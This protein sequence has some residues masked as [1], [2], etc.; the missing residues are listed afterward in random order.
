MYRYGMALFTWLG[1]IVLDCDTGWGL[2]AAL[3]LPRCFAAWGRSY[4][5]LLRWFVE[6]FQRV[7]E[8]ARHVALALA[9]VVVWVHIDR[10]RPV[11]GCANFN[12]QQ[13]WPVFDVDFAN[14]AIKLLNFDSA[15]IFV[16]G[17]DLEQGPVRPAKPV[18]YDGKLNGHFENALFEYNHYI[19]VIEQVA[20]SA[21]R[22]SY[23]STL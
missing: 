9:D 13:L 18:A 12:E 16:D 3:R 1:Q 2:F 20:R 23:L 17:N 15:V 6:K 19:L 22:F 4:W 8:T 14:R 5:P 10:A 7:M 21:S 11:F